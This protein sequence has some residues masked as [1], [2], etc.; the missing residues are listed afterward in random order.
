VTI[1]METTF[2]NAVLSETF[3]WRVTPAELTFLMSYE[4][5]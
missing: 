1:V 3:V 2:E 5:Q 4:T